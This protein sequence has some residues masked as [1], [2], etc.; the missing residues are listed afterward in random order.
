[1][2]GSGTTP[3]SPVKFQS[4]PF[5]VPFATVDPRSRSPKNG[6]A[7]DPIGTTKVPEGKASVRLDKFSDPDDVPEKPSAPA[8]HLSNKEPG[9]A[10]S[11]II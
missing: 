8:S 11:I 2:V 9:P 7:N 1:V 10:V 6:R 4:T 5:S 3:N